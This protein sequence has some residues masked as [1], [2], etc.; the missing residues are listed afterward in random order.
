M[1]LPWATVLGWVAIVAYQL[2]IFL[3]ERKG[4]WPKPSA[5]H[6]EDECAAEVE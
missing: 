5:P 2:L 6:T 1:L 3:L 4:I